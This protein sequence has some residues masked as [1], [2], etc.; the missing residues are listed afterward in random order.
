MTICQIRFDVAKSDYTVNLNIYYNT[1]IKLM[2]SLSLSLLLKI[3]GKK[4]SH[5]IWM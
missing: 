4:C 5:A 1:E 3:Y 2:I